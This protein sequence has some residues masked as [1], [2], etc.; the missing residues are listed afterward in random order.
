MAEISNLPMEGGCACG[1]VQYKLLKEPFFTHACHCL[2]CQRLSGGAFTLLS[3]IKD[4]DIEVH[5]ETNTTL[6]ST[7]S[8]AGHEPHFCPNCGTLIWSIYHAAPKGVMALKTGTLD[9]SHDLQPQAHIFTKS[10]LSWVTLPT[11]IPSHEEFYDPAKT[12]PL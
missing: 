2:D 1:D 10:K 11:D 7:G 4:T 9:D 5:G 12:W 3:L 8:G 6:L